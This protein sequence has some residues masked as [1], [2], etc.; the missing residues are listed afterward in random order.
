MVRHLPYSFAWTI[1]AAANFTV[2]ANASVPYDPRAASPAP[3]P[4]S[5]SIHP[6]MKAW[7]MICDHPYFAVTQED[8]SFEIKN[9]PAGVELEFRVWQEAAGYLEEVSVNDES[10]KWSKGRFK[11]SLSPEESYDMNV[12]VDSSAFN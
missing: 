7:M 8:G 4:V 10:T 1:A 3:I 12:V 9:V 11:L 6:W 5:C 2:P